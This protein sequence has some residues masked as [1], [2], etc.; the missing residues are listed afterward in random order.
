MLFHPEINTTVM[1]F[2][3]GEKKNQGKRLKL[4]LEFTV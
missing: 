1:V 4:Q 2:Y 3:Y